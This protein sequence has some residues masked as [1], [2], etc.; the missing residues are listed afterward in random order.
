MDVYDMRARLIRLQAERS[1]AIELGIEN[2]SPYMTR[3]R[4]AIDEARAEYV[5]GA[6]VEIAHLREALAGAAQG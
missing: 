3:L 2:P 5:M 4:S 1:Q 6:V